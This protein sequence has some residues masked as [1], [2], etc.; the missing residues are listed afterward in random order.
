MSD[1]DAMREV[2]Q[3]IINQLT[4]LSKFFGE[5]KCG[6]SCDVCKGEVDDRRNKN[7]VEIP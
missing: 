5:K 6:F 4:E 3:T 7:L 1:I 2:L